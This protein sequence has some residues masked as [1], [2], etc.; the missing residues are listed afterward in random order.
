[1]EKYMS[2]DK[3][4]KKKKKHS[5]SG[6]ANFFLALNSD[7]FSDGVLHSFIHWVIHLFDKYF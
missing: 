2:F 3:K 6:E 7:D 5:S 1:M 4:K